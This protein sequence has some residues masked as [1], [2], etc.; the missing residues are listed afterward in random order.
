MT[1][2]K[3]NTITAIIVILLILIS[4][5]TI[6]SQENNYEILVKYKED[7]KPSFQKLN[8]KTNDRLEKIKVEKIK[9]KN[10]E[11]YKK[12]L[13]E[14]ENRTDIEYFEPNKKYKKQMIPNDNYHLAS[15][16]L[17]YI[18]IEDAWDIS[19]GSEE[20]TIA[21]I[22][23]GINLNDI[24]LK[25]NLI[26][27][28]DFVNNDYFPDDDDGHG[29]YIAQIVGAKGNNVYGK[30]GVTWNSK[31]MPLKVLDANGYG[32][33]YDIANAIE[34]AVNNG[35]NIINL[36]LG[37]NEYSQTIKDAVQYAYNNGVLIIAAAGNYSSYDTYKPVMYPAAFDE[38]IAVGSIDEYESRA[39]F[40][41]YGQG[42]DIMAPGV[43]IIGVDKQGNSVNL[44]GTSFSTP[45]V[46]GTA[47]LIW[48]LDSKYT[49]N[50]IR[51]ILENSTNDLGIK[52]YDTE[53]GYGSLNAYKALSNSIGDFNQDRI[54]DIFDIVKIAKNIDSLDFDKEYDLNND[55]K[56]DLLD[57]NI[58][59]KKYGAIY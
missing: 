28:Y 21:V 46:S 43:N 47:A 6:F 44:R 30:A 54:V 55:N 50:D 34:Y 1:K 36:S 9:A 51:K 26:S 56:L 32:T 20:I 42:L 37:G 38:V 4:F 40:S 12:L 48:S 49:N 24:D 22:D 41:G 57:L 45:L 58:L 15:W 39:L 14:L 29:T 3:Q 16:A 59:C 33:A 10:L 7:K 19:T 2:N 11:E 53:F 8:I 31:L 18:N 23:T 27:G 17:D 5:N 13:K 35:A 52:G 25:D